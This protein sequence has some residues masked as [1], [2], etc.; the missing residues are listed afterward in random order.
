MSL[1]REVIR[2]M[3][4]IL[5][6]TDVSEPHHTNFRPLWRDNFNLS[7]VFVKLW[8]GPWQ[9]SP[10]LMWMWTCACWD[11]FVFCAHSSWSQGSQVRDT[12]WWPTF[13]PLLVF[14]FTFV[15]VHVSYMYS[16]NTLWLRSSFLVLM[17]PRPELMAVMCRADLS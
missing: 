17:C 6:T 11:H 8:Q 16:I 9:F 3:N 14:L 4:S 1:L 5:Q 10:K 12:E 2:N 13:S 7:F 15:F